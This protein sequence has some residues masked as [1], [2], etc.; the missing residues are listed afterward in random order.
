MTGQSLKWKPLKWWIV[1]LLALA[2]AVW[3]SSSALPALASPEDQALF[4]IGS[5][6]VIPES[7][8]VQDAF[9]IG[10]DVTLQQRAQV[11]GDIF[12]IG[13]DLKLQENTQVEGDAFVIG[14]QIIRSESAVV[15]GSEFTVLEQLRGVFNRFGVF[16]TLYLVNLIFWLAGFVMAAIAGVLLL[17]LLPAHVDAIATV[18]QHRP[19]ASLIYGIGGLVALSVVTVLTAGSA[20]GSV[21]IPLANLALLLTGLFG[22]TAICLWLGRRLQRRAPNA[23]FQHFWLGLVLLFIMSLIP[24]AG[25]LLVSFIV[26]FGLGATLLS[27]YGSRPVNSQP[28]QLDLLDQPPKAVT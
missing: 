8:T 1:S 14:G 16:G 11:K 3:L 26:L 10:G 6:L 17:L 23:H 18:L 25:G 21:L 7:Q 22:G 12:A 5:D 4:K 15:K 19:F 9:S 27:R 24:M 13:G 20:L 28:I 2:I